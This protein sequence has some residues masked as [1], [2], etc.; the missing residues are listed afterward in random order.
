ML[1]LTQKGVFYFVFRSELLNN[2]KGNAKIRN[3]KIILMV[4]KWSICITSIL[5]NSGQFSPYFFS[6]F[7]L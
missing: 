4:C 3:A 7:D 5:K 6:T 2:F 1:R